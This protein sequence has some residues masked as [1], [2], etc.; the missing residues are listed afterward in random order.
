MITGRLAASETG[1]PFSDAVLVA[2][3]IAFLAG[4]GP[5]AAGKPV[6]GTMREQARLTLRNL[7]ECLA[8]L[9]ADASAV[10][11]CTCY[12]ADLTGLADFNAAY[13]EFFGTHRPARTT[14]CA[15]LIGGI[16]LEI[17]AVVA[18]PQRGLSAPEGEG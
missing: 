14:V 10:V 2:G 4:Q 13:L 1:A 15:Q 7:G 16:G 18:M 12:L 3:T 6:P 11:N 8:R 17:S 9:G 5:I